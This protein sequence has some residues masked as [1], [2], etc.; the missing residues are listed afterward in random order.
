MP[1]Q[2]N[3]IGRRPTPLLKKLQKISEWLTIAETIIRNYIRMLELEQAPCNLEYGIQIIEQIHNVLTTEMKLHLSAIRVAQRGLLTSGG[4]LFTVGGLQIGRYAS[5]KYQDFF[6]AKLAFMPFLY[7]LFFILPAWRIGNAITL[8]A[9][10]SYV[11]Y[12]GNH[13][14]LRQ[15]VDPWHQLNRLKSNYFPHCTS[16][17]KEKLSALKIDFYLPNYFT[18]Q[19]VLSVENNIQQAEPALPPVYL[20]I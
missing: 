6:R 1:N 13:D 9:I 10:E 14:H 19:L 5:I 12:T 17:Q 3:I 16:A 2:I 11:S 7:V 18:N 20:G 15:Y 4:F 8:A